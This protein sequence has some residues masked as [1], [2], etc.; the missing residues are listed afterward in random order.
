MDDCRFALL[1]GLAFLIATMP[2]DREF[3]E[4]S[5]IV[6][7]VKAEHPIPPSIS[8][9]GR[10]AIFCD[11]GVKL[12][13]LYRYNRILVYGVVSGSEQDSIVATVKRVHHES[14]TRKVLVQFY[15][16]ENWKTWSDTSTGNH[17]GERGPENPTRQVWVN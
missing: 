1:Y 17:D 6:T 7:A 15:E 10:P 5:S 4:A 11:L 12:P 14:H 9:P 3:Y 16:K 2:G 8:T 13:F